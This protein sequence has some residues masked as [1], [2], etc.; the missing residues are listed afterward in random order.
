MARGM[1]NVN[2]GA[3]RQYVFGNVSSGMWKDNGNGGRGMGANGSVKD[4]AKWQ[5]LT[6]SANTICRS[7]ICYVLNPI[8][9]FV[10][11][12]CGS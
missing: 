2:G 10:I 3:G 6:E 9:C 12:G 5:G 8:T 1:R 7:Y 4:G 11:L